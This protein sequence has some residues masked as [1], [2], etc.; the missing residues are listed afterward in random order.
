[1]YCFII[2]VVL[3]DLIESKNEVIYFPFVL[4]LL[5]PGRKL[6]CFSQPSHNK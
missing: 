6:I 2:D 3:F 5:Y 4:I 1:M